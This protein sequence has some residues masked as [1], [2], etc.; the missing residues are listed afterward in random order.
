[1]F[2]LHFSLNAKKYLQKSNQRKRLKVKLS[3]WRLTLG[4]RASMLKK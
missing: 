1:M 4:T 2:E 3:F